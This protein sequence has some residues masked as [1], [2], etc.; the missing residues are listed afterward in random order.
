MKSH[1]PEEIQD[2]LEK[3]LH[4]LEVRIPKEK[5][6][7]HDTTVNRL[8]TELKQIRE[9]LKH[10]NN[11][12]L[13][14]KTPKKNHHQNQ[15]LSPIPTPEEVEYLILKLDDQPGINFDDLIAATKGCHNLD[16]MQKK[17]WTTYLNQRSKKPF[18][19]T[20]GE[21]ASQLFKETFQNI[22][23]LQS[24]EES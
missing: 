8:K 7:R 4:K 13:E 5:E 2:L 20:K 15:T 19:P 1:K 14:K 3:N 17:L 10:L 24:P 12:T 18:H 9:K 22:T 6:W 11:S 16:E 23:H 21:E